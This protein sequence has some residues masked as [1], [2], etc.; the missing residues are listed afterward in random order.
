MIKEEN[1]MMKIEDIVN[2]IVLVALTGGEELHT[3]G[4]PNDKFYAKVL[5]YD[6]FGIWFDNP[7][8]EIVIS[9]D[10]TGKPLPADK[11]SREVI[12]STIHIKW[13]Y[14]ASIVHFPEREG[15]DFPDPFSRSIGFIKEKNDNKD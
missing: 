8:F 2:D 9:E 13:H 6:E 7:N 4:I 10:E 5:G 11:V 14:I 3:V 15:F 1:T 12:T